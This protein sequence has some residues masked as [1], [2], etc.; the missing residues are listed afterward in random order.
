M[1]SGAVGTQPASTAVGAEV[2]GATS[3]KRVIQFVGAEA[4]TALPPRVELGKISVQPFGWCVTER[5]NS[6]LAGNALCE[7]VA[8]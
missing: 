6:N 8:E 1:A 5:V 7:D 4:S 3:F 2:G